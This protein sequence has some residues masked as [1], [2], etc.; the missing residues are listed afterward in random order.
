[1]LTLV[2]EIRQTKP[3][4][5]APGGGGVR[6]DRSPANFSAFNIMSMGIAWKESTWNGPRPPPPN[7]RAV[8]TPLDETSNKQG[9]VT[10]SQWQTW[11]EEPEW[12][13]IRVFWCCD[14]FIQ[15]YS[16]TNT[17]LTCLRHFKTI[18]GHIGHYDIDWLRMQIVPVRCRQT[19]KQ[20]APSKAPFIFASKS[21]FNMCKI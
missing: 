8:A 20:M 7:R 5:A 15:T 9:S 10:S 16:N 19:Q 11:S 6:G 1:M 2:L 3:W 21:V 14:R 17:Y 12:S 13:V 4:A 18:N